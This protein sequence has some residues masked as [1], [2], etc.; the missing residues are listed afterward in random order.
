MK[1]TYEDRPLSNLYVT[2]LRRLNVETDTFADNTGTIS[3][4]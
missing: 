4:I 2:M 1:A 3:E